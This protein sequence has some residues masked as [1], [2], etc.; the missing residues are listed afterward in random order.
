MSNDIEIFDQRRRKFRGGGII[1]NIVFFAAWVVRSTLKIAEAGT[2]I[3]YTILMAVLLLSI[4]WMA[5]FG[6]RLIAVERKIKNDPRLKE[7]LYNELVR[8][9]ELKAWRTAF[10][11][12][13]VFI[14]FAGYLVVALPIKDPML[15]IITALLVGFGAKNISTYFLD[16]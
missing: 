2:P 8:L 1:G 12:L 11:S 13:V 7:A 10:F 16:K 14:I 9:N 4:A 15:I 5:Y 3:L 6:F